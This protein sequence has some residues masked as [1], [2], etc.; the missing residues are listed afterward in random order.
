MAIAVETALEQKSK[1]NDESRSEIAALIAAEDQAWNQGSAERFAA[2]ALP[3]EV[4]TNVVGMFSVGKAPFVAQHELIFSTIH[5]GSKSHQE[6]QHITFVKPDVA[7]VDTLAVV[8]GAR[9]G[10]DD[11]PPSAVGAPSPRLAVAPHFD[12]RDQ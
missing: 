2:R 4:F 12:L 5:K 8:E 10:R 7:I 1:E 11:P 3:D 9:C 6:I